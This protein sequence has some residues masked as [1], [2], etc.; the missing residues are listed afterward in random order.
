[1]IQDLIIMTQKELLRYEII[2]RLIKGE[3]NGT[4]A[5]KQLCLSIRQVKNL[6]AAVR[7]NGIKGIIH[8]NRGKP[9]NRRMS[10][11]K[12]DQIEKTIR[13][14]YSDFGPTFAAEKLEKN[15]QITI[16]K[17]KLRTLLTSWNLWKPKSRKQNKE[18]RSWRPRKEY[19]GEMEQFDGS[20]HAWFEKRAPECCLLASIDDATGKPTKLRFTHWESVVDVFV[21][22]KQYLET[23]GKP[24]SI[25]L[26]RHSTYKNSQKS[27]FDDPER[28]T[29]FERAIKKDLDIPII[30]AHS[31][32]AK[33]RIERLF[34]T[35]QDRLIKE[36][37]LT[38]IS[39]IEQANEFVEKTFIPEFNKRFSVLAQKKGDLH[40]SLTKIEESN[41]DKIFSVQNTRIVNNDFTIRFK[42][43]WFQL[44]ELQPILVLRKDKVLIEERIDG[45][46]FI[47]LRNKNLGYT[48][49][50]KRPEKIKMKVTA[51]TRAQS[52]WK[53]PANHP[54]RRSFLLNPTKRYQ[55]SSLTSD[56]S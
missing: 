1:M 13:N 28:L 50:P 46:M 49:L 19:F 55:T 48:E 51:L 47:S 2:K 39:T 17:E 54:W 16:S 37:R 18:F 45:S 27:V 29:Q 23:N 15:H 30:H 25:Y 3:I 10:A 44:N 9:G 21:F 40:R 41:L 33:G 26:D 6:K 32:Q 20:Y 12:I 24:A 4:E 11:E 42:G 36:L 22:W 7:R 8:G 38:D 35:L 43:G 5:A 34:G 56:A 52:T 53:P 14:Q 31:P